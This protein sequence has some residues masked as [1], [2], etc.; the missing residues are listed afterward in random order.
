MAKFKPMPPLAELKEAFDYDP[1]TGFFRVKY[2]RGSLKAGDWVGKKL[3]VSFNCRGLAT[4]RLAW[5]MGTGQDPLE[6]EVD[7][8]DHDRTHNYLS[9]LR[10]ATRVQNMHNV[11]R[12]GYHYEKDRNKYRVIMKIDGKS[13]HIGRFDSAEEAQRAYREKAVELRGAFTPQEWL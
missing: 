3:L 2:G 1:E 6:L 12:P 11:R 4:N 8:I 10:L 13:V 9:N 5:Y 7:H